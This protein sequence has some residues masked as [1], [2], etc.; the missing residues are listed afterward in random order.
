ML[1]DGLTI[2]TVSFKTIDAALSRV[3]ACENCYP[4]AT[5]LFNRVLAYVTCQTGLNVRYLMLEGAHCPICL[6]SI[7]ENTLVVVDWELQRLTERT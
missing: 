3:T 6:M 5:I 1:D 4:K 7:T 2:Y